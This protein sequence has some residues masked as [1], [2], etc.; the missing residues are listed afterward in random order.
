MAIYREG[1]RLSVSTADGCGRGWLRQ[2]AGIAGEVSKKGSEVATSA[3]PYLDQV[4]T[5]V[6]SPPPC[7]WLEWQL[8][9]GN[10]LFVGG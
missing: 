2:V 9:L 4:D 7:V 3:K 10:C 1:A 8:L 6:G 5:P